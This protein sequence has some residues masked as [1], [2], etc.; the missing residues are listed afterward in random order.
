MDGGADGSPGAAHRVLTVSADAGPC[1]ELGLP[2]GT[3]PTE[4]AALSKLTELDVGASS[5]S[6][7]IPKETSLATSLSTLYAHLHAYSASA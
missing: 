5:I 2:L 3:L 4:L 1:R 6:G 7:T